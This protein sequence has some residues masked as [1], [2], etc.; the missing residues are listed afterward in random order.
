LRISTSSDSVISAS[1]EACTAK[2]TTHAFLVT[3]R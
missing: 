2:V 1:I 3:I